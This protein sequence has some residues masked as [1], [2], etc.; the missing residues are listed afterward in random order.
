MKLKVILILFLLIL[1]ESGA[2]IFLTHSAN[3]SSNNSLFLLLGIIS[4]ILVAIF[5][6][7]MIKIQGDLAVVN[8]IWQ[9]VNIVV[10]SLF[11]V[12]FFKEKLSKF[13]MFGILLTIIGIVLVNLQI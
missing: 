10:I 4:Y 13:Q 8:T 7:Y 12:L 1:I 5:F 2:E 3:N 6:Y 11:S 9:G